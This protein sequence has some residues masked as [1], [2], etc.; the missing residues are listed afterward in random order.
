MKIIITFFFILISNANALVFHVDISEPE[1][2]NQPPIINEAISAA[3]MAK[4]TASTGYTDDFLGSSVAISGNYAII[5]APDDSDG[6]TRSGAAYIY[7]QQIDGSWVQVNKLIGTNPSDEFGTSVSISGGH[8]I[9]GAPGDTHTGNP[10][11]SSTGSAYIFTWQTDD[12]WT[13]S[14]KLTVSDG[15]PYGVNDF[16]QSVAISGNQ[17]IV[18]ARGDDDKGTESGSA[19]IYSM[20]TDGS[21]I[22][23]S[24]ITASDGAGYDYFGISVGIS[25]DHAIV[26]A[27]YDDDSGTQ[28]GTAFVYSKTIIGWVQNSKLTASDAAA[29]SYFGYSV[30]ISDS[31]AVVGAY[32][33]DNDSGSAYIYSVQ[34]DGSW[35]Q[36]SKITAS[37]PAVED[38]FGYSV[39]ISDGYI[40]VGAYGD[41]DIGSSSGSAY[42]YTQQT[43]NNWVQR[44][45]FTA[46][47]SLAY[48]Q[49]GYSVGISGDQVIVAALGA[50]SDYGSA[51]T[52]KLRQMVSHSEN[53][54][55]VKTLAISDSD[56]E[57]LYR[58]SGE[59]HHL[60][61]IDNNA[62]LSFVTAPDYETPSDTNV[63]NIYKVTV[64]ATD[65]ILNNSRSLT[66]WI[67]V[68]DA[69]NE[70][71]DSDNIKDGW[72]IGYFGDLSHDGS[73]D[74]DT[75]GRTDLHEYQHDTNPINALSY[76][77][78]A[79]YIN[80]TISA[81]QME[82]L[83]ANDAAAFDYSGLSV[84][85]SGDTA[86]VGAEGNDD[87]GTRSG[88]AYIYT[89]QPDGG[90]IQTEKL[91]AS[92]AA[93]GDRFGHSVAIN[94][95]YA[96][97]GAYQND[98]GDDTDSGS[99]YIFN[100]LNDGSWTQQKK[101]SASDGATGDN[102]G[103][104]VGIDGNYAIVGAPY[105]DDNGIDSGSAYI[106]TLNTSEKV[107]GNWF[108]ISTSLEESSKLTAS[109]A[110]V[111]DSF[112]LSVGISGDHAIVGAYA[113]DDNGTDSGSAYIYTRKING[114][115]MQNNILTAS[116]ATAG[117]Y[118]GVSTAIDG[119]YAIIGAMGDSNSGSFSG[120]AYIYRQQIDGSWIQNS[121]ITAHDAA[122]GDYF[123]S[124]VSISDDY[125]VVGAWGND[126]NGTTS[127]A[128]YVY[129]RQIDNS[130]TQSSKLIAN[131]ARTYDYFGVSV[132]VSDDHTIVGAY[133]TDESGTDSGSAYSF[134]LRQA[135]THNEN[136][137]IVKNLVVSDLD[138]DTLSYSL[139]GED[140]HLFSI[141]SNAQLSFIKAPDYESPNDSDSDNIYK[142]TVTVTDSYNASRSLTLWVNVTDT[143]NEDTDADNIKDGW[144]ISYFGDLSHD[145][146]L[147][148]DKDGLSDLNEFTYSTNPNKKDTD[149]DSLPDAWE[150]Q[151]GLSPVI[152]DANL[153]TDNDGLTNLQEFTANRNPTLNEAAIAIQPV[154]QLLNTRS[155]KINKIQTYLYKTKP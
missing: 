137:P 110:A 69:V 59:D 139:S 81:I 5:G 101:L 135:I 92:D 65:F 104:S 122:E 8:A 113:N 99:A 138:G 61:T 18:G 142:V 32:G 155:K 131:D 37:D 76:H 74:S 147:D 123:G 17:A 152:N 95:D 19:Y 55:I 108:Y 64:T 84:A 119:N 96:I 133:L 136:A 150:I 21:W 1:P 67:S 127:G 148:A 27:Y 71:T 36:D 79:P 87:N 140:S 75:D 23:D 12:N 109:N 124:S 78:I 85:I 15:A 33:A 54:P 73:Q 56:S 10:T 125:A 44:S 115:W 49:F 60:F 14:T 50:N 82:K 153:D 132:S 66:L 62:Q 53:N 3:Q 103:Y 126:D 26:G 72:E 11:N 90:W 93:E 9:I 45:K 134:T 129:T 28:S 121:I 48:N 144:E 34:T 112:G 16:G 97:V 94:G 141:D 146:T 105:D 4:L 31:H 42:L 6:G 151:Y 149:G 43:D 25:G 57:I 143:L 88:S 120:S 35:I 118:F 130:W 41:D 70:D 40:V 116:D 107:I 102:F 47:D 106:F 46:S 51:Y 128:A 52:F 58:L 117:D 20:Q 30:A 38:F 29:Y 114:I 111:G 24:K 7:K 2:I 22:Q 86:I 77:T 89:R 39:A 83:S 13:L 80:E 68:I 91:I 100:K 98:Y 145:G 63:D 154:L